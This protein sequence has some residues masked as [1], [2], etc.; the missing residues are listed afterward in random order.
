MDN[1]PHALVWTVIGIL[2][3]LL[4]GLVWFVRKPYTETGTTPIYQI[5][6]NTDGLPLPDSDGVDA[7]LDVKG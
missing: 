6:D 2:T 1:R 3:I 5:E 7:P 4:V